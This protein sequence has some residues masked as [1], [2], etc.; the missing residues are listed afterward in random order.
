MDSKLIYTTVSE[1]EQ[2]L[3]PWSPMVEDAYSSLVI[4][5]EMHFPWPGDV[6]IEWWDIEMLAFRGEDGTK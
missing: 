5:A 1:Y 4:A 6:P 3:Q 2:G